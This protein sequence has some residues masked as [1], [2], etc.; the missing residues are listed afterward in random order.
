MSLILEALNHSFKNVSGLKDVICR[1]KNVNS[2]AARFHVAV[3][4][5]FAESAAVIK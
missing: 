3:C 5:K 2:S 1:G 4:S